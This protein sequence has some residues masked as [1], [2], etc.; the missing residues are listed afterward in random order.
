MRLDAQANQWHQRANQWPSPDSHVATTRQDLV[1][2][3]AAQN[4]APVLGR[5]AMANVQHQRR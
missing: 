5:L 4:R 2:A 1:T 3:D